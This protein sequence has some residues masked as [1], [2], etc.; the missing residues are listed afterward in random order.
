V[1]ARKRNRTLRPRNAEHRRVRY[2]RNQ[3]LDER[4]F[5][6]HMRGMLFLF[7]GRPSTSPFC[8]WVNDPYEPEELA[9]D[10]QP[11]PYEPLPE[12]PPF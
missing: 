5:R 10:W 2:A 8:P 9:P 1:R 12:E 4:K 6:N 11:P 3:E 7:K